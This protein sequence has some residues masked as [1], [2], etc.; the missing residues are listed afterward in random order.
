VHGMPHT[1]AVCAV[2]SL[3]SE[4]P[5]RRLMRLGEEPIVVPSQPARRRKSVPR[6]DKTSPLA[7]ALNRVKRNRGLSLKEL[8]V[9]AIQHDPFRLDTPANHVYG[10]W[11]A[12]AIEDLGIT[13][14][15]NRGLHYTVLGR[16]KPDG[17][18][19]TSTW[20][21]WKWLSEKALKAARWLKKIPFEQI[22]DERNAEPIERHYETQP[23]TPTVGWGIGVELPDVDDIAPWIE[24]EN[25]I[26]R[27]PFRLVF[28]GEK[29]SLAPRLDPLAQ[30]YQASLY[31]PTGEISDTML[32]RM[33]KLGEEDGRE[34][35]V[36]TFSDS[37]P[38]GW[39][40]AVSIAHKLR[41]LQ[42]LYFPKLHFRVYRGA[43]TPAQ[44]KAIN[45]DLVEVGESP[46]PSSPL[47]AEEKRADR[48]KASYGVEQTE[49][50]AIATLRP[51]LFDQMVRDITDHFFDHDLAERVERAREIWREAAQGVVDE[52]LGEAWAEI[53]ADAQSKLARMRDEIEEINNSLAIEVDDLDLPEIEIP[54]AV[55]ED[56]YG[57]P[58]T[59]SDWLLAKHIAALRAAKAYEDGVEEDDD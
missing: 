20:D 57:Q 16:I 51:A 5:R 35:I 10:K 39:Q 14:I 32:Y 43:L 11:V 13:E 3:P 24:V 23:P 9:L 2:V 49:I 47:K 59:D 31:L 56:F 19:Y 29:S 15:H 1:F 12:D 54:E 26:G 22:T 53:R 17:T 36:I 44:V 40:M 50:D 27:Q 28:F 52:A 46:L 33:A 34:M 58:L 7:L 18:P 42:I 6:P 38:S 41:A 8:T 45:K 4:P 21:D 37:D 30:E 55:E 48:W 25:F